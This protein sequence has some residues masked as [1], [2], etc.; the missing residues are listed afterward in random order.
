MV[1]WATE[2]GKFAPELSI[3]VLQG[4]DRKKHFQSLEAVDLML[5]TYPLLAHD[6]AI[7]AERGWHMVFL[8]EAQVIKNANAAKTKL[9]H[10]LKSPHRFCLNRDAAGK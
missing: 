10:G 4:A 6:Q 3:L 2:P 5:T 9:V 7:L 1:N 8:D